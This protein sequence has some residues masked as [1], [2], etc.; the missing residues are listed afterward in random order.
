MKIGLQDLRI[1]NWIRLYANH[2]DFNDF[3]AEL[4]DLNL[5]NARNREYA[6]V[7]LTVERLLEFGFTKTPYS[8]PLVDYSDYRKG[9][10]VINPIKGNRFEIEFSGVDIE[11]R[12]YITTIDAVHELQNI[13]YFLTREEL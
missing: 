2:S 10:M 9:T 4:A 11:K 1:G 3:Q 8:S 13:Y 6:A 7:P 12:T 5:I